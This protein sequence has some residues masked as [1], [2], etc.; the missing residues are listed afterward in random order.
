M[1]PEKRDLVVQ[2]ITFEILM[3]VSRYNPPLRCVKSLN[4]KTL[5]ARRVAGPTYLILADLCINCDL[6]VDDQIVTGK[7]FELY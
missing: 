2:N 5:N 1:L 3:L 6:G 4:N 7:E